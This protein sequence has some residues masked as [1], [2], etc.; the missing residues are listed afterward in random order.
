MN[1]DSTTT[2]PSWPRVIAATL[3]AHV[4]LIAGAISWVAIYSHVLA[5]GQPFET[6]QAHAQASGPWVSLLL[7]VPLFYLLG[8]WL[9][10]AR[11]QA[12]RAG[13]A[14]FACV[15]MSIDLALLL[16]L[17]PGAIPWLLV[18]LNY[19]AKSAAAWV[20]ATRGAP[21]AA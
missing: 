20:G 7:G 17:A 18:A 4:I 11:P 3:L 5:P 16:A 12:A 10:R 14:A 1:A 21:R 15:Y 19:A 2:S 9:A 8:R 13:A 6:Y